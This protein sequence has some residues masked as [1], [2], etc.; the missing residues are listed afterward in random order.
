MIIEAQGNLV[1]AD[2]EALVNTVNTV[3]VMGKGIALQFK[4]AYPEMFKAYEEAHEAGELQLG[5][6]HVW[7]TGRLDH[8]RYIVNFP[9][10]GHWRSRSNLSDIQRGLDD[11]VRVIKDLGIGS[12]AVPPL[13]CGNGGLNWSDVRPLIERALGQLPDVKVLLFAPAGAPP[14]AAMP[15]NTPRP[16]WEPDTA[17]LVT[18]VDRYSQRAFET[19]LIEVQKLMYFLQTAG[20]PLGFAWA[21]GTYGPYS[22]QLTRTLS[23]IEGH[24]TRGFG[25]GSQ[26]VR[27]AEPIVVL[28]G[29]AEEAERALAPHPAT[30]RRIDQVLEL[31]SGF[32][33]A[34]S[35][36][37]LSSV[38]WVAKHVD[39]RAEDDPSVAT[40]LL[41]RW[42][43]RKRDL[44]RAD[45]VGRAWQRLAD[46]GWLRT[47][48]P[49]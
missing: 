23:T 2:A 38:H 11:L 5:T 27:S 45:H 43:P 1:T 32:E 14:P 17:S 25:D 3:G 9:T 47:H 35:M 29:A 39:P 21:K 7:P 6:M 16:S 41:V 44:F 28:A 33:S 30:R 13:G 12:I 8:P 34:Y 24:F 46:Q 31:S 49:A 48:Q 36:E 10:K 20:E 18:L 26:P 22:Q 42:S 40:E 15:N 37:L 4:R 19:S